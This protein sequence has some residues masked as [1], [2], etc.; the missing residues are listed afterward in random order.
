MSGGE[1][2]LILFVYLLLF[3]AKGVPA[4]AQTMGKALYQFR[5][6][7][8]DVQDEIMSSANEIR[9]EAR[10]RMD[11][12]NIEGDDEHPETRAPFIPS[13][14]PAEP[15]VPQTPTSTE[16]TESSENITPKSEV[17]NEEKGK[18]E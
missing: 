5:N 14:K 4:L 11:Q 15:A 16:N 3:G 10:A 2:I 18:Q 8:K 9:N 1:I 7:A 6:A 12:L 17:N 13:N